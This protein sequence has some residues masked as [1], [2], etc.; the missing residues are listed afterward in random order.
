MHFLTVPPP[1]S[2][3]TRRGNRAPPRAP[4][5]RSPHPLHR[6]TTRRTVART[7]CFRC[8]EIDRRWQFL[9]LGNIWSPA[10]CV[11]DVRQEPGA[12][13]PP[14]SLGVRRR[15]CTPTLLTRA[16]ARAHCTYCCARGGTT[17]RGETSFVRHYNVAAFPK[18]C[19]GF[20]PRPQQPSGT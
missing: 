3:R 19:N 13:P 1:S 14:C 2:P 5:S 18:T 6:P 17:T 12:P 8:T 15:V 4:V 20:R 9:A 16:H 10:G 7:V 11:S